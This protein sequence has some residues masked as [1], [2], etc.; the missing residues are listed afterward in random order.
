LLVNL[1][2]T[3]R[4]PLSTSCSQLLLL[5]QFAIAVLPGVAGVFLNGFLSVICSMIHGSNHI[6]LNAFH[7]NP[8]NH[9]GNGMFIVLHIKYALDIHFKYSYTGSCTSHKV[10]FPGNHQLVRCKAYHV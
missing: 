7:T 1:T 5:T 10:I 2:L 3:I 6:S 9:K 8:V 4:L